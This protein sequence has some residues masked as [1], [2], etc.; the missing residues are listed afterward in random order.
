MAKASKEKEE[1]K[2]ETPKQ[3]FVRNRGIKE[4]T[5]KAKSKRPVT[6][7]TKKEKE[8]KGKGGVITDKGKTTKKLVNQAE[9]EHRARICFEWS[10]LGYSV[11]QIWEM[12]NNGGRDRKDPTMYWGVTYDTV[13]KYLIRAKEQVLAK[14]EEE[15]PILIKESRERWST[16]LQK[17]MSADDLTNA[18][19]IAK[20]L[21]RINGIDII[22]VKVQVEDLRKKSDEELLEEL[23]RIRKRT[24]ELNNNG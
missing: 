6:T 17:A 8:P 5:A 7:P 11:Y 3:R 23:N 14:N 22:N 15:I 10:L 16:L 21:D 9:L 1:N 2:K 18:R 12:V 20:E 13:S 4:T 19:N 24:E